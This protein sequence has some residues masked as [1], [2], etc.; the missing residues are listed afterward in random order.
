MKDKKNFLLLFTLLLLPSCALVTNEHQESQR[1]VITYLLEDF[2]LPGDSKIIEPTLLL[3]TGKAISGRIILSSEEGELPP[4]TT[5]ISL[6]SAMALTV[7][8]SALLKVSR[9][10]SFT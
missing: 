2:P 4:N 6:S 8:D 7:E 3:G 10:S 5:S 9:V 1:K